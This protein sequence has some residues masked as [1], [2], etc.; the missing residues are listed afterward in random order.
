MYA[1]VCVLVCVC[2]FM[3]VI[4]MFGTCQEGPAVFQC[5]EKCRNHS[6]ALG[7]FLALSLLYGH[8]P[9]SY[10]ELEALHF[11]YTGGLGGLSAL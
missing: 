9:G 5:A 3:C 8:D 6:K 10:T 1:C 7:A 2:V 11:V 4:H